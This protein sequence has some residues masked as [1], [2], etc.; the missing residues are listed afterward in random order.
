MQAF[1]PP[2]EMDGGIDSDFDEPS[3]F[4]RKTADKFM[5]SHEGTGCCGRYAYLTGR[6]SVFS[7]YDDAVISL[8]FTL[9]ISLSE[10]IHI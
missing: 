9:P 3:L 6:Q 7:L 8:I 4:G 5:H 1:D 10:K 2:F